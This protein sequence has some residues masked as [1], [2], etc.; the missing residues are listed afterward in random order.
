MSI[1]W[2]FKKKLPGEKVRDPIQG[3]FFATEAIQG[4]AEALVREGLQ[5]ALDAKRP[6]AEPL[7]VRIFLAVGTD[8]LSG[9][10]VHE[11]FVGAWRHFRAERNGLRNAPS[12]G[13]VCP[14]LVFEDFE[15]TGLQ[16]NVEQSDEELGTPNPFFYF[17]RAEG[18][19][20]KSEEDRGRWG[21]GKYVFPR[22]SRI[23]SFFGITV[24]ADD[25][26]HVM[27]GQ[28]VLKHHKVGTDSYRPDG[29]FGELRQDGLVLPVG[30]AALIRKFSEDFSVSRTTDQPGLSVVIPYID[31]E[32]T[33][34]ALLQA[35]VRG[36]FY[37]IL[38][39]GVVATV[40]TPARQTSIDDTN[41]IEKAREFGES[42]AEMI[43]LIQLAEWAA[44]RPAADF[45]VANEPPA[46]R[47]PKWAPELIPAEIT[48]AMGE[49][50][51]RNERL[52]VRV[53]V[54]VREGRE[55]AR[56]SFFTVFLARDGN[57]SGRPV[58]VREGL[59]I[60]DVHAL[61]AR[62]VRSLVVVEDKPLA[63]MLGDSENPAHTQWQ[64]DSSNFK[65]KYERG[66][67]WLGFV[68]KSVAEIVRLISE[69]ER[70]EDPRLLIDVFSLPAAP[71]EEPE[72]GPK[73]K[74]TP[75][76]GPE[77]V[78]PILPQQPAPPKYRMELVPG[79]FAVSAGPGIVV[80]TRMEILAAYDVRRGN[81]FNK[82]RK[83]A[84]VGAADFDVGRRPIQLEPPPVGAEVVACSGNRLE[85]VVREPNF[86]FS[87]VGFDQR[88]D[89]IARV[90]ILEEQ[91]V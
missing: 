6:S 7:R 4:P 73:P 30:D 25:Q 76:P 81:P 10:R 35:I 59:I 84:A 17:F 60:S 38:T 70:E 88:R 19:T 44:F 86:R 54:I 40:A 65:G 12:E 45:F 79:G 3:E 66:P 20:S 27:M 47:A 67:S 32:I 34:R 82:Y 2:H 8:A 43:P 26:R 41:L 42:A 57:E 37:P 33:E 14:F 71:E 87:V 49:K 56:R 77:V 72:P 74:P 58:F 53:P 78:P 62:G 80:P 28:A 5:N 64:K 83:A 31:P 46:D 16:G 29:D 24:R 61:R 23:N 11:Y 91:E 55:T 9:S 89:V 52:A 36:Y 68:T 1:N 15:T 21:V 13:D 48:K 75:E 51:R 90:N 18:L 22:S 39:G 69:Q 63:T 50:F 85:I